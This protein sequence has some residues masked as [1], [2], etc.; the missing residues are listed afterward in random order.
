[1]KR[2][3]HQVDYDTFNSK[4]DLTKIASVEQ[5]PK[6]LRKKQEALAKRIQ[7]IE[8]YDDDLITNRDKKKKVMPK[9]MVSYSKRWRKVWDIMIIVVATYSGLFTPFQ[10]AFDYEKPYFKNTWWWITLDIVSTIIYIIDIVIAFRSSYLDNFG[11]EII[12]GSRIASH[13]IKSS[14]FWTDVLS[15]VSNPVVA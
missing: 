13:Y 9:C 12:E 15:L 4:V 14:R 5:D 10:L 8:Q 2:K 11:D 6:V 7:E 1:M 3:A